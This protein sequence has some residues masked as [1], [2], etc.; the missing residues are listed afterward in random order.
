MNNKILSTKKTSA[1]FLAIVLVTGTIAL[2]SPSFIVETAQATSDHDKDYDDDDD[3]KS[4][5]K[6]RDDDDKS[7]DHTDDNNEYD[8]ESTK[9]SEYSEKRYNSYDSE[10]GMDNDSKDRYGKDDR[11]KSKDSSSSINIKKVK[12]NNINVNL[13]GIDVDIGGAP[14]G[15]GP[16]NGA[17]AEAQAAEDDK[18]QTTTTA[19]SFGNGERNNNGYKQNDKDFR[20]VCINNNNNTVVAGG[21]ATEPEE[22]PEPETASLTVNKEVFGCNMFDTGEPFGEPRMRCEELQDDSSLWLPCTDPDVFTNDPTDPTFCQRLTEN[23]FDIEVLDSQN[24]QLQQFEGSAQGTTIQ[25]LQPGTY[26][27][28]EIKDE[29]LTFPPNVLY[30]NPQTQTE[31]NCINNGFS[32]G[33]DLFNPGFPTLSNNLYL[34][35]FKYVDEQGDDCSTITLAA[36]ENK[37]CTVK[38]YIRFATI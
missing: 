28:N 22:P 9:Y 20:F 37:L 36:G 21:N 6:D 34:I 26:A 13:N 12:C 33:G 4:Y 23:L 11:D 14:N 5:G 2:S 17:I 1:I 25:N 30:V 29:S 16:A 10:Y 3:K 18:G 31:Q 7:R 15:N 19:S 27:V 38:N 8:Y 32:D 24:T 35:C